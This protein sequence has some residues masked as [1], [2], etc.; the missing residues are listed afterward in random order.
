[1][2][3]LYITSAVVGVIGIVIGLAMQ[4]INGILDAWWKL[5][6]IFS[7]GMLGL[8]L[9][10]LV[11]R[12]PSK[13]GSIIAVIAGLCVIAY[14]SLPI[15]KSPIHTYLTIVFGTTMIF[16]VGFV[17]TKLLSKKTEK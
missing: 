5:S 9:L 15:F 12:K 8:F 13:V 1:M 11:V 3:V 10:S 4:H 7:G 14:M 16:I 2:S 6:S 17:L